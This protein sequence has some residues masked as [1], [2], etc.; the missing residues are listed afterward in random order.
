MRNIIDHSKQTWC[1]Q[2]KTNLLP[3][4]Q[5]AWLVSPQ[6][7]NRRAIRWVVSTGTGKPPIIP[8][9]APN[10]CANAMIDDIFVSPTV[11]Y[12]LGTI[13]LIVSIVLAAL[14]I[15]AWSSKRHD[16]R[17]LTWLTIFFQVSIMLQLLIGMKLLDQGLGVLQL[18]IHYLGGT[19][20]L[21]F[22][23]LMSW[24]PIQA[25][26]AR[27]LLRMATAVMALMF[28]ALT[29]FV[30]GQ[31]ARRNTL[32]AA[33]GAQPIAAAT[34]AISGIPVTLELSTQGDAMRFDKSGLEAPAG[35]RITLRFTNA[36]NPGGML[37]NAVVVKPGTADAVG[38]DAIGSNNPATWLRPND[39]RVI[40]AT[41]VIRGGEVTEVI[42]DAPPPGTYT[43]VCT[44]PG[45]H[46]QMQIPL[47]I[48]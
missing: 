45:H 10:R 31:F 40:A 25:G 9:Y 21:F 2:A 14:S 18:Y 39:D 6:Q 34:R 30:G 38:K 16:F 7:P 48:R 32:A 13:V 26:K 5:A 46:T 24:L 29:Y 8:G 11:H 3:T 47:V 43:V 20:P 15:Y 42:F 22:F 27:S 19:A 33:A 41:L 17:P 36:A 44:F 28:V 12:T 1:G 37:H 4:P 35:A 23:M